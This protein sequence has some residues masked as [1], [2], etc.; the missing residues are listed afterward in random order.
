M[1]LSSYGFSLDGPS[2][3]SHWNYFPGFISRVHETNGSDEKHT[4][5]FMSQQTFKLII[6]VFAWPK[7]L[8][9]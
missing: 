5:T 9:T 4:Q 7:T 6:L 8:S 2:F 1:C 3:F